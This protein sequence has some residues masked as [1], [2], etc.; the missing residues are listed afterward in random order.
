MDTD[1][2]GLNNKRPLYNRQPCSQ[3]PDNTGQILRVRTNRN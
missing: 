2:S 3:N 1:F